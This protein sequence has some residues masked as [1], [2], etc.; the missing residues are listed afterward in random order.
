MRK[1][2][3]RGF[4]V[5]VLLYASVTIV[6]LVLILILSVL[7]INNE[8]TLDLADMVKEQVSGVTGDTF[9]LYNL[10][11]NGS[12]ENDG[13]SWTTDLYSTN[14]QLANVVDSSSFHSGSKSL[15]ISSRGWQWQRIKG[16]S[17][18]DKIYVGFYAYVKIISGSVVV[19]FSYNS[20]K[21]TGGQYGTTIS[22][23][24]GDYSISHVTSDFERGGAI[25]VVP[26]D[27]E[28]FVQLGVAS[29]NSAEAFVDDIVVVN[30]TKIFGAGNE[31]SLSWC[32]T[33]IKY[34]NG[35][36]TITNYDDE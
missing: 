4:A 31:P 23:I 18:G 22:P 35:V 11:S 28:V 13:T 29:N 32:N 9:Q 20:Q 12:F 2:D 15:Y 5:S 27:P 19:S 6:V 36:T 16:V 24:E 21:S 25:A 14:N 33:N 10:I 26:E 3:N 17:P 7:S 34:F 8:N 1:V 30:L